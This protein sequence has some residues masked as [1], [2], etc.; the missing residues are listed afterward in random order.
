[1]AKKEAVNTTPTDLSTLVN[2]GGGHY[3]GIIKIDTP[4]GQIERSGWFIIDADSK[5][6]LSS[7][8]G[9][10]SDEEWGKVIELIRGELNLTSSQ[11]SLISKAFLKKYVEES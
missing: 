10:G 7:P 6:V 3:L 1:M 8:A 9:A 2:M 11:L 5:E 4:Y